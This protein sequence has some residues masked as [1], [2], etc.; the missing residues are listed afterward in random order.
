MLFIALNKMRVLKMSVLEIRA[1]N[2]CWKCVM[3]MRAANTL[4]NEVFYGQEPQK[5]IYFP[6]FVW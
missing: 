1:G 3:E 6:C 5:R 4:K 2:P